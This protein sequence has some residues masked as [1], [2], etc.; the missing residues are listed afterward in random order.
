MITNQS[1]EARATRAR[2]AILVPPPH[3]CSSGVVE[4]RRVPA[5]RVKKPG[6]ALVVEDFLPIAFAGEFHEPLISV[7]RPKRTGERDPSSARRG[8]APRTD[9][10]EGSWRWDGG[11]RHHQR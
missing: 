7:E 1:S 6:R 10:Q 11:G 4:A 9:I 8:A 5:T 3:E 2:A